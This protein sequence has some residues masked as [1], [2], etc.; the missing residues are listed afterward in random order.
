MTPPPPLSEK[1]SRLWPK[2]QKK[3]GS[4]RNHPCTVLPDITC[5][6]SLSA[7]GAHL[8]LKP[9]SLWSLWKHQKTFGIFMFLKASKGSIPKK[10][11]KRWIVYFKTRKF[12]HMKFNTLPTWQEIATSMTY[13]FISLFY[14][15]CL[16]FWVIFFVS[17][18]AYLIH[19]P[20]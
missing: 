14:I 4:D 15:L 20:F 9:Y 16:P 10:S 3:S 8:I 6:W 5:E 12:V 7:P 1:N 17:V 2:K 18:F 19:M 13:R 11:V